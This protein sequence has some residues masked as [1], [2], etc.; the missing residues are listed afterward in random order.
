MTHQLQIMVPPFLKILSPLIQKFNYTMIKKYNECWVPD[1]ESHNGLAGE[2]SHPASLPPHTY[3]IGTLSRFTESRNQ[4]EVVEIPPFE[5]LVLLSG[6]EPQRTILEERLLRQLQQT[7]IKTVLVR[8]ITEKQE[9]KQLGEHL[10]I[11]SHLESNLLK[12]YIRKSLAVICR[13]GYSSIMD[14]TAMG[15]RAIFIPT[16][17]QTEQEY[18]ATYLLNKKIYFS[19]PQK[20]FDLIYALEM[21]K[22]FPGM[23]LEND[24]K[25]LERRIA[26][27]LP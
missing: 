23:V 16:P 22:N 20:T 24:Y 12:E 26:M 25:E 4:Q 11:F 1:F 8:G 14:I 21:S 2:L 13:S 6:P 5:I 3:Y 27:I 17:G 9:E 7:T 10:R 18:L 15:K 19:M